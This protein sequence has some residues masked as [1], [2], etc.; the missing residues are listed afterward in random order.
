MKIS[1]GFAADNDGKV[2]ADKTQARAIQL[3]FTEYLTAIALEG[4]QE[5]WKAEAFPHHQEISVGASC[6]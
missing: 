2:I 6:D 1:Y 3:I 4:W 5:C